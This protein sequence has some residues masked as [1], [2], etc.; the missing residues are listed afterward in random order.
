MSQLT[1]TPEENILVI[2]AVRS[3]ATQ[4]TAMYGVAD[5][6]LEALITKITPAQAPAVEEVVA[7]EEPPEVAEAEAAAEAAFLDDVPH[8]QHTE[9]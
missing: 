8:E 6:A 7:V 4:Y 9:E 3:K 5:P 1:L 2:D